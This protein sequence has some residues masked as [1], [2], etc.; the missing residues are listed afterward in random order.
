MFLRAI[1]AL[2]LIIDSLVV[3][4]AL[5]LA[6]A[7]GLR[8]KP[9]CLS[10][11]ARPTHVNCDASVVTAQME[12]N[13]KR[14]VCAVL[15]MAAVAGCSS[16]GGGGGGPSGPVSPPDSSSPPESAPPESTPPESRQ[17]N[18]PESS[19]PAAFE[20]RT[21]AT[22]EGAIRAESAIPGPTGYD[23]LRGRVFATADGA[24]NF[25]FRVD[26]PRTGP[27]QFTVNIPPNTTMNISRADLSGTFASFDYSALGTW[28]HRPPPPF[29]PFFGGSAVTGMATRAAD[30]P[31]TGTASY[32]GPFLGRY[33]D[34]GDQ[35]LVSASARSLA[36]FGTGVVSFETAGTQVTD[37]RGA[38]ANPYLDLTGSMTFL[39]SGGARR[40]ALRG[41]VTSKPDALGNSLG[42]RGELRGLFFGPSSPTSAPPELGGSVAA[43]GALEPGGEGRGLTGAFT[44][45]R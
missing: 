11:A 43:Q 30:L 26:D 20:Y 5:P 27:Y 35:W 12:S 37:S 38:F 40:N 9:Q 13:M 24:G 2:A 4:H 42:L 19:P 10:P 1:L 36:N 22:V 3:H 15:V 16:G 31:R 8:R 44:M 7:R 14:H 33:N 6:A 21:L 29:G 25:T 18:P 32:A 28:Q 17:N 34:D 23:S 41:T 39:S 45:R